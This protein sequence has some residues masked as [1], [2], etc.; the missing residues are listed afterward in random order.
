MHKATCT[1]GILR[2]RGVGRD[3]GMVALYESTV[4]ACTY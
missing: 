3:H 2:T 4:Q 1:P